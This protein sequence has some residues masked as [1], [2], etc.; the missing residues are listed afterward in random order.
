MGKGRHREVIQFPARR[1][2]PSPRYIVGVDRKERFHVRRE[3]HLRNPTTVMKSG[4]PQPGL[5]ERRQRII[6]SINA[7]LLAHRAA[8]KKQA[9]DKARTS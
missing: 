9:R 6:M 5:R 7:R 1:C 4:R 3:T 2:F 8:S